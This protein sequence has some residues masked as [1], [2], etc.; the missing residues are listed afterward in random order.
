[1][2]E[3]PFM[4]SLRLAMKTYPGVNWTDA[5]SRGQMRSKLWLAKELGSAFTDHEK[6]LGTVYLCASWLGILGEFLHRS[7]GDGIDRIIAFDIDDRAVAASKMVMDHH[8]KRGWFDPT[9]LDIHDLTFVRQ[10]IRFWMD[11]GTEVIK[12]CEPDTVINTSCE[13]ILDFESWYSR[14]PSSKVVALQSNNFLTVE[15]HIN[16]SSS[17]EEF[18][19]RTPLSEEW[20]SGELDLGMYKRFMRI[21]LT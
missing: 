19:E 16:C 6:S 18:S 21:G 3:D 4:V 9:V 20:F 10:P 1:M 7:I 2:Y 12:I 14:I 13:H 11:D 17:I 8:R 5:F 15:D